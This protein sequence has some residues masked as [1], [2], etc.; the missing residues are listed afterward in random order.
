M[1]ANDTSTNTTTVNAG[2]GIMVVGVDGSECSRHALR[3]ALYAAAKA[4]CEVQLVACW[5]RPLLFDAG[6][7]GVAYPAD[8]DLAQAATQWLS[9][10]MEACAAEIDAAVA[11]G[12]VV[13]GRTEVGAA[14]LVLEDL[15]KTARLLVVGRRGHNALDRLLGTTSRHVAD[16]AHC[17][18]AVIP[19][20]CPE[21]TPPAPPTP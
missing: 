3:W 9:E 1:T 4:P 20:S 18:V 17:P 11:A 2:L 19:D 14:D 10:T 15:S 6:G 13:N 21:P 16:H 12:C 7:L 8:A 5:Q